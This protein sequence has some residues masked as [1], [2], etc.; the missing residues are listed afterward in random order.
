MNRVKYEVSDLLL[1]IAGTPDGVGYDISLSK[2]YDDIKDA[3]FEED[4][5]VSFG[6]WE[7]ELKKADW[8]L[9]EKLSIEAIKGKSKDI[10]IIGW[11]VES[12]VVL[13]GFKGILKGIEI[14]DFYVK[15]FWNTCY[16]KNEDNSSDQEQKLK[17]LDWIFDAIDKRSRFIPFAWYGGDDFIN[18]YN[19]DYAVD[20]KNTMIRLPNSSN[21][22]LES[23]KKSGIKTLDEVQNIVSVMNQDDSAKILEITKLIRKS[24]TNFDQTM[25][26]FSERSINSFSG[27]IFNLEKI[28]NLFLQKKIEKNEDLE[29]KIIKRDESSSPRD[30]IYDEIDKLSKKLSVIERH[31]PSSSILNL[32]VSWKE[33]TLL[34]IMDD[35]KSGNSEAHR[36]LKFLIN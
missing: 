9:T 29:P 3:R 18:S 5:S 13:D 35:L 2:I 28:E 12:L 22:I 21:E 7:R 11:L 14:L 33:K 24:K 4:D 30:A 16:P 10:R 8:I 25:S 34:E 15:N 1:E 6:V 36:L 23:A 20:L 31:S 19:Y 26:E 17:I 32:I 27:L